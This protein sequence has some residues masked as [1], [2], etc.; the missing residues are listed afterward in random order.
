M[1]TY[2]GEIPECAGD[3]QEI[4]GIFSEWPLWKLLENTFSKHTLKTKKKNSG[5]IPGKIDEESR[6]VFRG[7]H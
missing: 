5:Q 4:P 7:M 3:N 1:E 6:V 2:L